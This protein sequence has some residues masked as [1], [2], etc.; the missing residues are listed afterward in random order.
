VDR[1]PA[2]ATLVAPRRALAPASRILDDAGVVRALRGSREDGQPGSGG[3]SDRRRWPRAAVATVVGG[4]TF[5][6]AGFLSGLLI[7]EYGGVLGALEWLLRTLVVVGA[8]LFIV[9]GLLVILGLRRLVRPRPLGWLVAIAASLVF[10]WFV[11]VP[12]GFG[13]YLTHLPSRREVRDADLGAR[14]QPVKLTGADGLRL[15]GWYVPSRNR[16]AVIALHG[17]G[18]NRL[19]VERHARLLARRGYGVLALDLRGHGESEGRSTSAPWTMVDDVVAAVEWLAV[20]T[21][22]SPDKVA[23]LGVSMGGEVALRVAARRRDV[24]AIVAEGVR[25]GVED[26]SAAG[27]IWLGVAQLAVLEAVSS[28]LTGDGPGSGADLV[29]RIAPRPLLLISA[30]TG[31]E[32]DINRLFVRRAGGSTEHWN[33]PDA[34]HASAIS[35][36]AKRYERRVIPFLN[37]ALSARAAPAR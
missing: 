7:D 25:G 4:L 2:W 5:V 17:T 23:L 26:A 21:D 1:S 22:V 30:G 12:V 33:L 31:V 3:T 28:V 8:G 14:K 35:T 34:A 6:V 11:A 29:E 19:G 37:R 24:R 10:V 13:V 15:R 18:S 36:D 16:A 32:A 9:G 27:E 20:R